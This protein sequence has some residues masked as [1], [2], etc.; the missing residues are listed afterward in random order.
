MA[1]T[2]KNDNEN[3]KDLTETAS[4]VTFKTVRRGYDP[5]EVQAYIEE[6]SRTMQD[7]SK[8]YE[9]RMAEMKAALA[10]ANRERDTL[11]AR[12]N[13]EP[14]PAPAAEPPKAGNDAQAAAGLEDQL[15]EAQAER[16]R[17]EAEMQS[18]LG[19][20]RAAREQLEKELETAAAQ[21]DGMKQRCEQAQALQAQYEQSLKAIEELK[22]KLQTTQ[23][24]K[25]VQGAE[26]AAAQGHFEKV[27]GENASL[28]TELSRAQV[29]NALLTEKNE[30]YKNELAQMKAEIKE[31]AYVYAEK[32]SAGEDEL[33]KEQVKLKK[34]VQMQ[35]YH[36]EQASAAVEELTRQLQAIQAS[37]AE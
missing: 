10:L 4:T 12:F 33:R 23:D 18:R 13:K 16:I 28:K 25:E 24:E 6:M 3:K 5:A 1:I 14:A 19:D 11:L 20:E 35:N 27:E 26:Y 34:K 29:E 32:L 31:K 30:A 2:M 9:N 15:N 22:A 7:A 37:F 21:I 17:L 36:I 8:N